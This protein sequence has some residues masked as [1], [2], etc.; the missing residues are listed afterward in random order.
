MSE[1]MPR[2]ERLRELLIGRSV[3]NARVSDE[4]PER[5]ATGPTGLLTMDDGTVLKVWGN[6]GG[7]ACTAGCYPL[8][9]LNGSAGVI[10]NVDVEDHP[11][12]DGT[13]SVCAECG[14]KVWN[15][16][17]AEGWYRIFVVTEAKG[18]SLLASFEGTD[19]NG[20]YGTGWWLNVE[21]A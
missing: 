4:P 1:Y 20:Y 6:D 16:G 14:E 9:L 3:V 10:T 19:G 5:Y 13:P 7:C 17:H 8:A 18:R 15:C 12:D 11:A 21:A 2:E